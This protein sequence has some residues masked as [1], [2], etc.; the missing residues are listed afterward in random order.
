L[1][2]PGRVARTIAHEVRNP[3]TNISLAAEQ[4]QEVVTD[5]NDSSMLLDMI[6]RNVV[7]INE[8]VS[9]LLN[10]TKFVQLDMHKADINKLMDETLEMARDR[11]ELNHIRVEKKYSRDICH[12]NVD[13]EKIKFAFLNIIV[14]SI[15]AMEKN[16]GVLHI[17]NKT[18][19]IKMQY[20]D[21]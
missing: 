15:E 20:R 12:V 7:R 9:D 3:L 5:H 2:L 17:K 11:I 16:K 10:A 4:L 19:G 14:N 8:L 13:S 1:L 6:S 21:Q 18:R